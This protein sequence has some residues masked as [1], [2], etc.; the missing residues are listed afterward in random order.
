MGTVKLVAAD[1][2]LLLEAIRKKTNYSGGAIWQKP[3]LLQ[4]E[5]SKA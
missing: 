2:P 1:L 4:R 5:K 3:P